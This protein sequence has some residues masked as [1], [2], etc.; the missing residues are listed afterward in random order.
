LALLHACAGRGVFLPA[1]FLAAGATVTQAVEALK[2]GAADELPTPGPDQALRDSI[3][4]AM[5]LDARLRPER[6]RHRQTAERLGWLTAGERDV[7]R[8]MLAGKGYKSIAAELEVSYKTVE[9]RRAKIMQKMVCETLAELLALVL[10]YQYWW[11]SRPAWERDGL[12]DQP[13]WA[14]RLGVSG[15]AP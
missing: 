6:D 1:V 9:A 4:E 8:R 13:D 3:R 12:P 2:Q 14:P 7:L 5:A 15:E 11:A 10:S